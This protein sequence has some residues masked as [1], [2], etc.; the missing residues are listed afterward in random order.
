MAEYINVEQPFLDKLHQIGW[1][2]YDNGAGGVPEDPTESF[3][4][5]FK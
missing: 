1:V 4:T 5:S 2:V 3:R